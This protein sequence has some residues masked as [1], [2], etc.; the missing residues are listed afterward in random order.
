MTGTGRK[1]NKPHEEHKRRK[2]TITEEENR[3]RARRE[4]EEER[5]DPIPTQSERVSWQ[6]CQSEASDRAPAQLLFPSIDSGLP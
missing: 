6:V 3:R 2:S 5:D 4:K 1:G